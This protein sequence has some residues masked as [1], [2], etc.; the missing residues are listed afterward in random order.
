MTRSYRSAWLRLVLGVAIAIHAVSLSAASLWFGDKDGL[1]R[2]DTASNQV[3]ATVP[4]EP[5]V[6]IAVSAT[7]GLLWTLSQERLA[8]LSEQGVLQFQVALRDLGTALGAPRHLV[9]NPNDGSVWA[10]FENRI[11]HFDATGALRQTLSVSARDLAVAQD[12][13][14]WILGSSALQQHAASGALLR[15]VPVA[16]KLRQLALDDSGAALWLAGEKDLVRLSLDDPGNTLASI[17]APETISGISVDLQTGD[18]WAIGQNGLF[19]YGRDATPRVSRDLRDFTIANPQTL[20]FDF[21]SQA[22]WVGHQRGLTRITAAGTVAAAFPAAPHVLTIAIGRTPVEITPV[23]SIVAPENGALLN[24]ATPELRVGYDALCSSTPCGFPNSFFSTFTLTALLNGME[25]GSSFAFDASTGGASFTPSTPLPQGVN[26]FSAQ[27]RDSFGRLSETVSSSFTVDTIAPSFVNVTPASGTVVSEPSLSIAGSVDD[28]TASV[29]LDGQTT[30]GQSFSFPVTLTEGSNSFTLTATDPAGNTASKPLTYVYEK[31]NV[32]PSVAISSPVSGTTFTAPASF[33]V[34][35]AASDSDGS[36]V[37]VDFFTNG[38]AAGSDGVAPFSADLVNLG[39][40]SYTL[41]AQATDN[42]GG[43]TTSA[44][45]SITVGLPNALPA[46]QLTA[47]AAGASYFA[48]ATV[49]VAATAA[50]ADGSIVSVEFL[51]NGV[52]EATVTAPPYAATLASVPAG[53]HSLTARA[54]D[55]RGGITTSSAVAITVNALSVTIDSPA[56]NATIAGDTMVIRG[57]IVAPPYS[58]VNVDKYTGAVDAAGNFAI[59][60][61]LTAGANTLP[62]TMTT[63]DGTTTTQNVS[64]NATGARSAIGLDASPSIGFGPMNVTYTI[65]N[66]LIYN[67]TY[68]IDGAGPYFLPSG[69]YTQWTFTYPVGVHVPTFVFNVNGTIYTQRVVIEARD[70]AQMDQMFR[71]LWGGLNGALAAGN[72]DAAMR[73]LS[74]HGK[75]KFGPVFDTLLPFMPEIVASYSPLEQSSIGD[76]LAEYAVTRMDGA[77]RRLYLIYFLRDANGVWRIDGM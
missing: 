55:D 20:L 65:S 77:T 19:A 18:L 57:R 42:R 34:T 14:L 53:A 10:A 21:A 28:E 75:L 17:L 51:R 3:A 9:L 63:V 59:L 76:R 13:S 24:D 22:A 31:P 71:A 60:V 26:T 40:G 44:P 56:P 47:P 38:V 27:A 12:G 2:I 58:G 16:Q 62:V 36:I 29:T 48:P 33:T 73:Y 15:S 30:Q 50:D 68:T 45:V 37:R 72:K 52:V 70:K 43:V 6:G 25:T 46:V 74:D 8:R 32:P 61:P 69:R 4:F 66:P 64:V 54:T 67:I 11:L 7:D 49:Q 23:V 39:A 5:T 41:T 1:H 35:A